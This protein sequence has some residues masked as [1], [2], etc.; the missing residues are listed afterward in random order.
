MRAFVYSCVQFCA[1]HM[2]CTSS[3]KRLATDWFVYLL[4]SMRPESIL[5]APSQLYSPAVIDQ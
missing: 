4:Q 3:V 1:C 2:L 5:D